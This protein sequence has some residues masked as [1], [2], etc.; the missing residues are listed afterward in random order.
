MQIKL[1]TETKSAANSNAAN[2]IPAHV[3]ERMESEWRQMRQPQTAS[4][5]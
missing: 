3:I 5:K 4:S 2:T 1:S